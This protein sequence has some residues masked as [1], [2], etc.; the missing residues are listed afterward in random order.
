MRAESFKSNEIRDFTSW[1]AI[2]SATIDILTEPETIV[3]RQGEKHIIPAEIDTPFSNNVTNIAFD[4]GTDFSSSGLNVSTQR[5]HPPVF[6][7]KVSPQTPVGVYTIPFVASVLISTTNSTGPTSTPATSRVDA[8]TRVVDPEFQVSEKYPIV[9]QITSPANLTIDVILPLTINETF[10][11]IWD[12]YATHIAIV[13]SGMVG[14]LMT[15]FVE[16]LRS[17]R[18]HR[19]RNLTN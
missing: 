12:T 2:P 9:G 4:N 17:R 14:V 10:M 7:V 8:V 13:V 16:H 18:E 11:T 19:N 1:I 15:F 5:V 3:I 6:E